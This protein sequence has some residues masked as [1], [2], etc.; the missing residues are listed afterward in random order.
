M[1]K[2]NKQYRDGIIAPLF[3][4]LL[5][6]LLVFSALAINLCYMQMTTTQL[7]IASDSSSHAGGRALS[8]FQDTQRAIDEMDRYA[9]L[10]PVAGQRLEIPQDDT[11][12][13]FG[14]ANLVNGKY[15]FTQHPRSDVDENDGSLVVNSVQVVA[16]VNTPHAFRFQAAN[17]Q[18]DATRSSITHQRDR[19][20]AMVIDRSGSM[21]EYIDL[22]FMDRIL[23]ALEDANWISEAEFNLTGYG[24]SNRVYRQYYTNNTLN[25]MNRLAEQYENAN[26]E[27]AP[28][29]R[30]ATDYAESLQLHLK[31]PKFSRNTETF[32]YAGSTERNIGS[33]WYDRFSDGMVEQAP[34]FSRW[35]ALV[36]AL[37]EFF[38]VLE[39]TDQEEQVA[40]VVFSANAEAE[41]V[42][43]KDYDEL[44][45]LAAEI[46]PLGG[47]EI[48]RGLKRGLQEVV[49]YE[50][51]G[52][53]ANSR[54]FAE[55]MIVVMTDG[56]GTGES[57]VDVAEAFKRE[58]PAAVIH[59]VT[60]G[61]GADQD[62]MVQ[63]AEKGGG[64]D[65][66]A[67]NASELAEEFREIAN[68]PPTIFTY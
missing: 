5:P 38:T 50:D 62:T 10:N 56:V 65:Y 68:I 18:F 58:N 3:A 13:Q 8:V 42:L 46:V 17:K 23:I 53:P 16:G 22:P 60:F 9:Q 11:H 15:E 28:R 21:L 44:R 40:L 64:N 45:E 7:K 43:T 34:D 1:T 57:P 48:G 37:D 24:Q 6:V 2:T 52:Q 14:E 29:I 32:S 12:M 4:F 25:R 19:D 26:H 59:T 63:V 49:N 31:T 67:N 41:S 27:L 54:P 35:T 51:S 39:S 36:E 33:D 47:T 20:I 66:H 55:K 61:E 30:Q